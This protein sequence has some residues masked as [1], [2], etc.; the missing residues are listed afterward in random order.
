MKN[1]D[2]HKQIDKFLKKH[3]KNGHRRKRSLPSWITTAMLS[4]GLG[5]ASLGCEPPIVDDN[6][7][8]QNNMNNINNS[9]NV[10]NV[11]NTNNVNNINNELYGVPDDGGMD[12][13]NTLYGA[14]QDAAQDTDDIDD[15]AAQPEYAAPLYDAPSY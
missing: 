14:P 13:I 1:R 2:Y 6:D 12:E 5:L 7:A 3:A 10:N 15:D 4:A 11:N 9:N 8:S